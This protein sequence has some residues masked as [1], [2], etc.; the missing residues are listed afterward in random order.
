VTSMAKPAEGALC[1]PSPMRPR[2]LFIISASLILLGLVM[3]PLPGPGA[4]VVSLGLLVALVGG[5]VAAVNRYR[6]RP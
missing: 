1:D 4:L 2:Y 3:I 6:G 5:V